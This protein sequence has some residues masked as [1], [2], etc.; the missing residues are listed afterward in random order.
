MSEQQHTPMRYDPRDRQP[1][2][3]PLHAAEWRKWHG[4]VAW[5]FN[6]WTGTARDPADIGSDVSGLLIVP[7]NEEIYP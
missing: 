1:H 3:Y 5:L 2:P 4:Q 7:P 6:P